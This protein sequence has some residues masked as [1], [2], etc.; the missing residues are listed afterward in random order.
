MYL[1]R[2]FLEH[3]LIFYGYLNTTFYDA[4][5][6]AHDIIITF[7]SYQYIKAIY[8]VFVGAKGKNKSDFQR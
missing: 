1:S 6:I 3:K 5:K 2:V 4:V 8:I 7:N